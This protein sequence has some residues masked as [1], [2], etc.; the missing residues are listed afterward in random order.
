VVA[1]AISVLLMV[2]LARI[3]VQLSGHGQEQV[4]A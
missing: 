3:Y 1:A 4:F 2:M